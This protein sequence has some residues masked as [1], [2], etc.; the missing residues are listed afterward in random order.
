MKKSKN[1]FI[2]RDE[3]EISNG[4]GAESTGLIG[5]SPMVI[6]IEL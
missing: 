6:K 5:W 2:N 1:L 4:D 3:I